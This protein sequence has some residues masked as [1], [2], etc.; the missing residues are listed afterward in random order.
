[1]NDY[2]NKMNIF[3]NKIA[4]LTLSNDILKKN[5]NFMELIDEQKKT[6]NILRNDLKTNKKAH[7]EQIE[8]LIS[9]LNLKL[10]EARDIYLKSQISY[11]NLSDEKQ[12]LITIDTLNINLKQLQLNLNEKNDEILSLNL[13]ID[14]LKANLYHEK[15][16]KNELEIKNDDKELIITN[17]QQEIQQIKLLNEKYLEK[18]VIKPEKKLFM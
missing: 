7:N 4:E 12:L 16:I 1:M 11:N 5:E 9:D 17:L 18:I 13:Q 6:I 14:T 2:Q 15:K 8:H 3:Q 10:N